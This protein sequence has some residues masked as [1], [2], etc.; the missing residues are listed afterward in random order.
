MNALEIFDCEQNSPEW[1]A[2]RRGVPTASVFGA[3]LAKGQYKMRTTLLY[4]LV[5]EV[6]ATE[7]PDAW[8]N[9]HTNRGSV[10]EAE[11]VLHY[12]L[13]HDCEPQKVGFMRRGRIGASPDRLI[14]DDGLLEIKTRL[15]ALQIALLEAGRVPPEHKPQLQGQLLVSGRQ[16]I[17][18]ACGWPG[19]PLFE[20]RVYRDS[21]YMT[22][23]QQEL[24]T[25]IGEL[26]ELVAKYGQ[27][28]PS[29]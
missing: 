15:P 10:M 11:M 25:F 26:D 14:G 17:D 9:Q 7:H 2:A 23:L 4:K 18:F 19:L 28:A 8:G 5:G 24:D 27:E 13:L 21:A 1:D 6:L 22:T 29:C 20:R 16:W 12:A 3:V